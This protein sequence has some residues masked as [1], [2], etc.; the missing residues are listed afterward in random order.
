MNLSKKLGYFVLW[1]GLIGCMGIIMVAASLYLYISPKLPDRDTY[2]NLRLENP[3][4][5]YSADNKLIAEFGSRRSTPIK[6]QEIPPQV[7]S[8]LISTEDKRFFSHHGVD[9]LG[10]VRSVAGILSNNDWGGGSTITM[11]VTKNFFFEGESAYTRKFKEILLALKMERE[12]SKEEILELYLNKTFFGISAYGIAA[13]AQQYYDKEVSALTLAEVA[14]LI[15]LLPRPN[16]Y[17]P[18]ASRTD[19]LSVR[20]RVL[21]RMRDQSM[22]SSTDFDEA[23]KAPITAF[24]HGRETELE[25]P[26]IAEMVRQD[27]IDR[28]GDL[29]LTDGFEVFTTIDSRMQVTANQALQ[30]GLETYDRKHGYRG[31]ENHLRPAEDGSIDQW[32]GVLQRT[33]AIASQQPAFVQTVEERSITALLKTGEQ[34]TIPWEGIRWAKRFITNS[35]WGS[36]PRSAGE[37]VESGDLIRVMQDAQGQ[38]MLGQV[39]AVNGGLVALSPNSGSILSLVGGYDFNDRTR[40]GQFNRVTQAARQPGSNFKPFLYTAALE[41]GYTS[42]SL[43][44]DA[45]LARSD[46]RPNNFNGEFM[47]P[48]RLSYALTNS[49]NLVSLRLYD[50]LGSDIVLPSVS[51]FGFNTNEFPGDDLTVAIGTHALH[52]L[53]VATGYAVF[54]NGGHKVEPYLIERI[55][56]FNDGEMFRAQPYTVCPSCENM[57]VI[58]SLLDSNLVPEI[59]EVT[60]APRVVNERVAYI[61]NTILRSVITNGSGRPA[62]RAMPDREDIHGK[63]G[64]TDDAYDLWFSGYNGNLVTTVYVGYDQP[65]TLGKSEQAAT[66]SL[67]IWIDFMKPVLEGTPLASMSQPD[68]LEFVRINRQTGLRASPDED[69][70]FFEVFRKENIPGNEDQSNQEGTGQENPQ[71][72]F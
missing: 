39:P 50:A 55:D 70:A 24:R 33:P 54:A 31:R 61:M 51:R 17:N 68:E 20:E 9:P 27:M 25:A 42:A 10:L 47:G 32:L 43:I 35:T 59:P 65:E 45:P 18:L 52:P 41:N 8:A 38:W 4:R 63:T 7:T 28:Y 69:G 3:L 19:S 16:A 23:V 53:E 6:Y 56:N 46:Y 64:T 5:I 12:L 29:A 37:V 44:N 66:V 40:N 71:S 62:N 13:A 72:P 49:K 15:G 34:I 58:D 11:Q 26:Y 14:A 30:N 22:I 60:P 1:S 48:I 21:V 57:A 2:T 67:P 36:S